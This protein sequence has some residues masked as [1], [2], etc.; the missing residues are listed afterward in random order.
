MLVPNVSFGPGAAYWESDESPRERPVSAH[1]MLKGALYA[2]GAAC[3]LF[4]L[5]PGIDT[6]V[7]STFYGDRHFIGNSSFTVRFARDCFSA[8]FISACALTVVGLILSGRSKFGWLGF[9]FD[10]WLFLAL[11][12][13]MGPLVVTNIG[14]KDHWGRARPKN[15]VEFGGDKIFTPPFPPA[16]QCVHN[17]SFVS[18]EA[19]SVYVVFFAGAFLL[20]RRSRKMVLLGVTMGSLAGLVRIAQGGH[21]LSDVI[22]AGVFM[23]ATVASLQLL[24]EVIRRAASPDLLET[25]T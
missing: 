6:V 18:G 20:R 22:F 1:N 9:K 10:K 7:S 5:A 23:A 21:F 8:F 14:L 3:L 2:G 12:L 24:F 25:A 19:S 15:V 4:L 11:C 17:C 16:T 13:V